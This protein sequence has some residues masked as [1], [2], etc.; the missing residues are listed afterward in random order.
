MIP[1]E[2]A[3]AFESDGLRLEGM[4]HEG[5]GAIAAVVLHPH[6][7]YGGDMDSHVVLALRTAFAEAGATTLRFNFR[8]TGRSQG[9][10][11]DGRGEAADAHAAI[12][13][14]RELRPGRGVLLAGYSFGAHV[15]ADVASTEELVGLVLVSLPVTAGRLPRIPEGVD[16]LLVTGDCD[17]I[18][19]ADRMA[20]LAGPRRRVAIVEGVSHAWWPG[21]DRLA[22]EVAVFLRELP[23]Q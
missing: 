5:D 20:A 18:A 8:G 6:P 1:D 7:L 22:A 23:R 12:S 2:R 9:A 10:Y 17:D 14:L 11:D 21:V 19:P 16:T 13:A 4:L 3:F 15:A